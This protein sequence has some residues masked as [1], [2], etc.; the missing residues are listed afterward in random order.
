MAGGDKALAGKISRLCYLKCEEGWE[1][2]EVIKY[3][4]DLYQQGVNL[5]LSPPAC[6]KHD[7]LQKVGSLTDVSSPGETQVAN[8]EDDVQQQTNVDGTACVQGADVAESGS[9][10][11]TDS[12]SSSD[13]TQHVIAMKPRGKACAK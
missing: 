10:D 6:A 7:Y 12:S 13:S 2:D 1:K 3:R 5:A 9:G 8:H 4:N 11:S